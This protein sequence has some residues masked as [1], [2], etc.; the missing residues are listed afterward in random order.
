MQ[1]GLIGKILL[2]DI[3]TQ[4]RYVHGGKHRR[5]VERDMVQNL[6]TNYSYNDN[7]SIDDTNTM[8]N[9]IRN[10]N[11]I[12]NENSMDDLSFSE[13]LS[14]DLPINFN[15]NLQLK[16]NNINNIENSM[17][18]ESNEL[19]GST[20][21][22]KQPEFSYFY[23]NPND[24]TEITTDEYIIYQDEHPDLYT[25]VIKSADIE[26]YE[27]ETTCIQLTCSNN[28]N[29][30]NKLLDNLEL[31][32]LYIGTNEGIILRYDLTHYRIPKSKPI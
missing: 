11:D 23:S 24:L 26:L 32:H 19:N 30:N 22:I 2:W 4:K 10:T 8:T 3:T 25:Q 28:N 9:T 14:I 13:E 17:E 1:A 6:L 29:S 21:T 20:T 18:M 31:K 27:N 5:R 12:E 7:I 15:N 16:N